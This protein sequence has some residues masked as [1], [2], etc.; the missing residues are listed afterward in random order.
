MAPACLKALKDAGL[1]VPRDVSILCY[2]DNEI[3]PL[4]DPPITS[5]KWPYYEMGKKA[6]LLLLKNESDR[7]KCI[8]ETEMIIRNSTAG[9]QTG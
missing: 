5:I 4:L 8:F 7:Q 3:M 6:A 9:L 1:N 2:I